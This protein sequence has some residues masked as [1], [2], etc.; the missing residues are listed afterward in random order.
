MPNPPHI[1]KFVSVAEVAAILGVSE[2]SV[3]ERIHHLDPVT[4]RPLIPHQR[5]GRRVLIP[6]VWLEQ[7]VAAA[8][9]GVTR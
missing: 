4:R 2:R 7:F 1:S 3:R 5:F 9:A 6:K 8:E